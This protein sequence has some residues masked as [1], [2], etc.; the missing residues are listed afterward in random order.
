MWML[1]WYLHK[2]DAGRAKPASMEQCIL[3]KQLKE[4]DQEANAM[5]IIQTQR[6]QC[7]APMS[8]DIHNSRQVVLMLRLIGAFQIYC[9][10]FTTSH[11]GLWLAE[12]FCVS[13]QRK[14]FYLSVWCIQ[15]THNTIITHSDSLILSI[16]NCYIYK[17]NEQHPIFTSF[18]LRSDAMTETDP[19]LCHWGS[20]TFHTHGNSDLET[21]LSK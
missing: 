16:N 18:R 4:H 10:G 12:G 13:R 15:E 9:Q 5:R 17:K 21:V 11:T 1:L 6:P 8:W 20:I 2:H 3:Q 19:G 14:F 7:R